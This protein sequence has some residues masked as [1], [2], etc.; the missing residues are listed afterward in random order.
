MTGFRFVRLSGS[1]GRAGENKF[2]DVVSVQEI[3]NA[4]LPAGLSELVVDGASGSKTEF[5]IE[6]IER[7]YLHM[8]NPDRRIDPHGPTLKALNFT[9]RVVSRSHDAST[10]EIDQMFQR[11]HS[12]ATGP[13]VSRVK[14]PATPQVD[15]SRG[16]TSPPVNGAPAVSK[17][18]PSTSAGKTDTGHK[19][20]HGHWH[21]PPAGTAPPPEVIAAARL[22]QARWGA[23][24]S[25]T[26]AQWTKESTWG[27]RIPAGSRNYFGIKAA[28]GEPFVK[29]WTT[30]VVNHVPVRKLL[31]FRVFS[32]DAECFD[33]HGRLLA[34]HPAYAAAR[35][36]LADAD[37]Y[38][39]GLQGH[40]ATD[41][42]YAKDLI[43]RMHIYQLY[44]YNR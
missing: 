24:A 44:R 31:N 36:H 41:E 28:R 35:A 7:R 17:T 27:H 30:E 18:S 16:T 42:A 29:A 20:A 9:R 32:S 8:R 21:E 3:I 19:D 4:H 6:T 14:P 10:A 11:L 39:W 37:A 2:S 12:T 22:S 33:L 15:V 38:A 43:K 1:V 40:Y 5:A 23:P 25:I 34:H 13:I 26:L